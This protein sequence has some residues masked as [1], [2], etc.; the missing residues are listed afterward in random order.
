MSI[1]EKEGGWKRGAV[2]MDS[3]L[4]GD[5]LRPLSIPPVA[6]P[7]SEACRAYFLLEVFI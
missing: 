3:V 1:I 4:V 7:S 5:T 2:S 6:Y